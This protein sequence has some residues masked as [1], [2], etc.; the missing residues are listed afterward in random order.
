MPLLHGTNELTVAC[1]HHSISLHLHYLKTA[2]VPY[3]R[4][5]YLTFVG[6]G[7]KFQAPADVDCS[8]LSACKRIGLAVRLLQSILAESIYAEVG[9][10]RTFTCAEDEVKPGTPSPTIPA[11]ASC[12]AVWC[13]E[14]SLSL[15]QCLELPPKELWTRV[16]HDL[17]R[18]FPHDLPNAKWLVVLSCARYKPLEASEPTP[19]THE[20][21]IHHSSGHCALGAG[22]LALFGPGTLY[23]WPECL[24]D[25]AAV[26]TD[27]RQVDRR[28][29]MD[30]S[31]HRWTFWANYATSLGTMLHELGHC[32][33]L[34]HTPEGIMRRGG[35]DVNLILAFPPPGNPTTAQRAEPLTPPAG[36]L[37]AFQCLRR[38]FY[39]VVASHP[40]DRLPQDSEVRTIDCNSVWQH[41]KAF[42]S[43]PVA[44]FLTHHRWLLPTPPNSTMPTTVIS[45]TDF[46][47]HLE[48]S[49]GI[50]VVQI[51]LLT[52]CSLT[53]ARMWNNSQPPNA[54]KIN[55]PLEGEELLQGCIVYHRVWKSRPPRTIAIA[56]IV[57]QIFAI[58]HVP[59]LKVVVLDGAGQVFKTTLTPDFSKTSSDSE[60]RT[61][62]AL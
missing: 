54:T 61:D 26:L 50:R 59:S 47:R 42:W 21:I 39:E 34:D 37:S 25:L 15:S 16:A 53:K 1:S 51:R 58:L 38:T 28:R 49:H 8:P 52:S 18:K 30:D 9:I 11:S 3:V 35:D 14:S 55:L 36:R 4:P 29:F 2:G 62:N 33:D 45:G 41:G 5:V 48:A 22:G 23:I 24:D 44:E 20:E 31:A 6:D 13:I 17:I 46:C 7:G 19:F 43:R 32:F 10:R 27:T 40:I 56:P 12:A 57:K 60:C